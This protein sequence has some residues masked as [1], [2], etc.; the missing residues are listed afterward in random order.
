MSIARGFAYAGCP[1]AVISLWKIDDHTSAQVMGDF[2]KH[3]SNGENIDRALA[4]A[5]ADY[6]AS[7][8]E[9]NSHP[10]YWAA[11]L[12][13]GDTRAIDVNRYDWKTVAGILVIL[14]AGGT[15]FVF[16]RK[17]GLVKRG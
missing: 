6:L 9:F 10:A 14:L 16:W 11:F 2:Y 1:S 8:S 5:K 12:Q 13:V 3:L 7:V 4:K 17:H 15:C